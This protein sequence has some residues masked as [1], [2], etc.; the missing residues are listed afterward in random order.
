LDKFLFS[1]INA[2]NAVVLEK[3]NGK[4]MNLEIQLSYHFILL[5]TSGPFGLDLESLASWELSFV[6]CG[7]LLV[8]WGGHLS[9]LVR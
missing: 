2:Q 1:S 7:E 5:A 6:L 3:M 9:R 8:G 4:N